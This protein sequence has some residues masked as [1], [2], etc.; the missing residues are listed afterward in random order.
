M[1]ESTFASRA[2]EVDLK[3]QGE[4]PMVYAPQG[5]SG[6]FFNRQDAQREQS[7]GGGGAYSLEG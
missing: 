4:L 2:F 5:Q 1:L 7:A 6:N 3:T